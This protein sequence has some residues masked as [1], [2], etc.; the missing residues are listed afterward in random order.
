[1]HEEIPSN[2]GRSTAMTVRRCCKLCSRRTII[3]IVTSHHPLALESCRLFQILSKSGSVLDDCDESGGSDMKGESNAIR[4]TRDAYVIAF[5]HKV[6]GVEWKRK[7][8]D[9]SRELRGSMQSSRAVPAVIPVSKGCHI[10]TLQLTLAIISS[11]I[12]PTA[13]AKSPAVTVRDSSS[14][15]DLSSLAT[16]CL[17]F[18]PS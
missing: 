12:S 14:R 6:I 10:R 9:L 1:V 5:S 13:S 4:S 16:D 17:L 11:S 8:P 18:V 2:G 7:I 15:E 3:S